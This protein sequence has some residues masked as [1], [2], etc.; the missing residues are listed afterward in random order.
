[1]NKPYPDCRKRQPNPDHDQARGRTVPPQSG[2]GLRLL[3]DI[4]Q[5]TKAAG[6][7]TISGKDA[8]ICTRPMAS[9]SR[10]SRAWRP[11][12]ICGSTRPAS[13]PSASRHAAI[14]RGTT[15]AAD[16]FSTGP[17]D[18]L[19]REYH[20]GSEFVGY[21]TTEENARVIGILEQN[22]L[23]DSAQANGGSLAGPGSRPNALLRRVRRPGRRYR[24][25]PRRSVSVSRSPTPRKIT[26]SCCTSAMWP[27]A[28]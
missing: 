3:N 7:E 13:R 5:K 14:S 2:N 17:L 20:H 11:T 21:T 25:D 27:R 9:R 15:E 10:S 19:K 1:M 6:S 24:H 12:T 26:I 23:A 4:F 16:V 18:T 22:R 28:R 8:F